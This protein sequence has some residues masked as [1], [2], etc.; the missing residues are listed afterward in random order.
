MKL[1][2]RIENLI[3]GAYEKG[4]TTFTTTLHN[5]AR[6]EEEEVDELITDLRVRGFHVTHDDVYN[7]MTVTLPTFTLAERAY[8]IAYNVDA[9]TRKYI[10]RIS[11]DIITSSKLGYVEEEVDFYEISDNSIVDK[12]QKHFAREGFAITRKDDPEH[13]HIKLTL[14]WNK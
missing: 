4:Q 3:E 7:D 8:M 14:R 10:E 5:F 13:D 11:K 1:A 9:V 6:F 12:L 2:E